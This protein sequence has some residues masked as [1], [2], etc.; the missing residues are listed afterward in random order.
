[1]YTIVIIILT[2]AIL[3][4]THV[5]ISTLR[6]SRSNRRYYLIF[7]MCAAMLTTL[8]YLMGITAIDR[9]GAFA[10]IK[11]A[12]IGYSLITPLY[13]LFAIDY[14]RVNISARLFTALRIVFVILAVS[15]ITLIWT[16]DRHNLLFMEAPR[17]F[18]P[19][20]PLK[21]F[22][23]T[24]GP[25][26]PIIPIYALLFVTMTVIIFVK[27][28][29]S[30]ALSL[31]RIYLFLTISALLPIVSN[32]V[33]VANTYTSGGE[34]VIDFT[35]IILVFLVMLF[36]V[37]VIRYG[38]FGAQQSAYSTIMDG[39]SDAYVV[40]DLEMEWLDA[41]P[42]ALKLFP[43]I[44]ECRN[45]IPVMRAENWPG[46]LNGRDT[47]EAAAET[48]VSIGGQDDER[49]F[50]ASHND[51]LDNGR[52]VGHVFVF[53]DVTD[54][55]KLAMQLQTAAYTDDLTGLYNRKHFLELAEMEFERASR[56]S[57]PCYAIIFDIDRF[58]TIN[59]TYG[60]QAGDAVLCEISARV[61]DTLRSYDLFARYGG[62]AFAVLLEVLPD[63]D[64]GI[65][66]TLAERIRAAA[67][68]RPVRYENIEIPVT[69]SVGVASKAY[70]RTLDELLLHADNAMYSA[71]ETGRNK[72]FVYMPRIGFKE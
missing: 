64:D 42:A 9:E 4:N 57:L 17:I 70:A 62:A 66:H 22:Q 41:N 35:P 52:R 3:I 19:R 39:L 29:L 36:R 34:Y 38:M 21:G 27:R 63:T 30:G 69:I 40:V 55:R 65:A 45:G 12:H 31:R 59:D 16:S 8:G 14:C 32:L 50:M 61:R 60:H 43:G 7:C 2:A 48:E 46:A 68:R 25:L 6:N 56:L 11:V 18:D 15:L 28:I 20:E 1:M 37:T 72:V 10:G 58:K 49:I 5:I 13:L 67:A 26:Y 53:R 47:S 23:S 54:L 44:M 33:Y 51:V 24:P 71:K